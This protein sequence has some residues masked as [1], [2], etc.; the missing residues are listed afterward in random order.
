MYATHASDIQ[1]MANLIWKL[2]R[3]VSALQVAAGRPI[4]MKIEIEI[5]EMYLMSSISSLTS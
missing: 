2:Q 1:Y 4:E 3:Q 5:S